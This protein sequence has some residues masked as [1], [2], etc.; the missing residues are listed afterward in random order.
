MNLLKIKKGCG[1]ERERKEI[2]I[3]SDDL[4]DKI[5]TLRTLLWFA[6]AAGEF[7]GFCVVQAEGRCFS[8]GE[9][10][11]EKMQANTKK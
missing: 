3:D 10:E 1:G 4:N 5:K 8:A 11:S 6:A 9:K 2:P 7:L